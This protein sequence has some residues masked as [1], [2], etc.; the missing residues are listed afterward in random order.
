ME[1]KNQ[2]FVPSINHEYGED[3]E[4]VLNQRTSKPTETLIH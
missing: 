1:G 4:D 3:E 2:I